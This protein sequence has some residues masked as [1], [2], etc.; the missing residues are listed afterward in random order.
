MSEAAP[1]V[2]ATS[3][4]RPPEQ[5]QAEQRQITELKVSGHL[6]TLE[7]GVFC[8]FQPPGSPRAG[9]HGLPGVRVSLPPAPLSRP[10]AVQISTFRED[11]WLPGGEG[12]A[13]VRVA[14][15]P[16]Q[17]LVT[18]YQVPGAGAD[19]APR[20]QVLRLSAEVQAAPPRPATAGALPVDADLVAHI[21]RTGDVGAKLGE[22]MGV[23]GSRLWIEGSRSRPR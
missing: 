13:L 9:E 1:A 3:L 8:I 15:G 20:L 7:A 17:V 2:P 18:V 22:W 10:G 14:E 23:R 16:A 11:G 5:R 6:M 21:Q 19:S 4:P 12:A